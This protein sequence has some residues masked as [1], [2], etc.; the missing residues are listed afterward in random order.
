MHRTGSRVL[1]WVAHSD[2]LFLVAFLF[3]HVLFYFD[4][5][6]LRAWLGDG[7]DGVAVSNGTHSLGT[8]CQ[9]RVLAKEGCLVALPEGEKKKEGLGAILSERGLEARMMTR[10]FRHCAMRVCVQA[11]KGLGGEG[12]GH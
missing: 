11:N 1:T 9:E 8:P 10:V 6:I 5:N 4:E 12:H 2:F 3:F 7:T